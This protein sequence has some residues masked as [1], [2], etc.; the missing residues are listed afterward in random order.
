MVRSYEKNSDPLRVLPPSQGFHF[1]TA[2]GH[3]CGVTSNSLEEFGNALQYICSEA[4]IFHF[5]RGD[6]QNWIRDVIGDMKLAQEIDEIKMCSRQLSDECCRKEIAQRVNIRILQLE[7]EKG[8]SCFS[9]QE[10]K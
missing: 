6:F 1:Y 5:E 8:N 2:V 4:I 3:Y 7:V 10:A 9:K